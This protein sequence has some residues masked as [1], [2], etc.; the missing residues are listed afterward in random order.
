MYVISLKCRI[1][2]INNSKLIGIENGL[3][4]VRVRQL[5]VGKWAKAQ[6]D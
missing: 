6:V 5:G 3:E 1:L 4:V 2:K